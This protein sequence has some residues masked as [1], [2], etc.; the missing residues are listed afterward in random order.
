MFFIVPRGWLWVVLLATACERPA[1]ARSNDTAYSPLTLPSSTVTRQDLVQASWD[2]AAGPI[3]LVVGANAQQAAVIVP[4]VDSGASLDTVSFRAEH[5]QSLEF[6]LLAAGRSLGVAAIGGAIALDVPDDC[7]AWPVVRLRGTGDTVTTRVWSVAFGRHRF[8]PL[9]VD[10]LNG[11]ARADSLRLTVAVAR[12]ASGAP[13]DTVD[14]L[15]GIPFVVKRAYLST[16]PNRVGIVIAEVERSLNQEASPVHEHLFLIA[17]RDSTVD[18]GYH[19]AYGE[20]TSGR[21]EMLEATELLALGTSRGRTQPV[22]L[23]ARYLGDGVVY[24]LIERTDARRWRLRWSSP[25]AGC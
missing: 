21:E 20:R 25:Y 10:S 7:S 15:R 6:D 16:L 17:E 5:W 22:L 3:F 2:S 4:A 18:A 12:L 13:G 9:A 23:V 19:L 1:P 8:A 14:A 11:L 24:S